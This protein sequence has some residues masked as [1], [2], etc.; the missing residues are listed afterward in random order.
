MQTGV[1]FT[2]RQLLPTD[3]LK[4]FSAGDSSAQPLKTF[5]QKQA[6]HFHGAH[7][8]K[9]WV[10][11]K[12]E[13]QEN[14]T[15]TE[16]AAPAVFGYITLICSEISL[17]N[18]YDIDDCPTANQYEYM[19]ALKIARLAVDSR[20]RGQG[21]GDQLLALAIAIG[22]DLIS[23]YIGCRFIITDAKKEAIRFYQKFGF[24]LLK[25]EQEQDAPAMFLDILQLPETDT[26]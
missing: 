13:T 10:A 23:P 9:T 5:L 20:Y 7:I 4:S 14:G 3:R 19:P 15:L 8:A 22:T 1:D 17:R 18:A 24:T 26:E 16:E 12:L 6:Q 25:T 21:I 2:I 11:V